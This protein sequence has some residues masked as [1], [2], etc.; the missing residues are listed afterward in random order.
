MQEDILTIEELSKAFGD[1]EV[2]RKIDISVRVVS[3]EL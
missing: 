3:N 2:L 1:H